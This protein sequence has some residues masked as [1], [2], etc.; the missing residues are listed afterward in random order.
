VNVTPVALHSTR[1][2]RDVLRGH[3][4][5]DGRAIAAAGGIHPLA[6]H[7]TGLSQDGLEALVQVGG[8][9]GLEVV[10]GD[11]W[12]LLAGSRSRLSAFAR[13]WTVPDVL[14]ETA[15]QVGLALP[16]DSAGPWLTSR[17]PISLDAPILIGILNVTPDSFSDGGRYSGLDAALS[18]AEALLAEGAGIVDVGGESTRPGRETD[19]PL[20]EELSRVVPV[21]D[22]LV[23]AHPELPISVDTVK[24]EVARAALEHGAAIVND[25]SAFRLDPAMPAVAASARA[26]VVLMHSR[27]NILEIASY[28]HARYPAGVVAEVVAELRESIAVA[29]AGGVAP[30]RIVIDPGLGFSKTVEQ[31]VELFDQLGALEALGRPVLVG[32]SRKRFLGALTDAPLDQRDRA[33]AV[34]CALAWER[35][36][37]IF[38]VHAVAAAR[39]A[40]ALARAVGAA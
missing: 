28:R 37:R 29:A 8:S 7:L 21:I 14:A 24:S 38:R 39:E 19:V 16:P 30:E 40:L 35:G 26:G 25:V 5:E 32:P 18:Q 1:G 23:R 2:L 34:A 3:G 33:T 31:N 6:L 12:A 4:W 27:G 15:V 9:L 11:D 17:G 20:A 36:A 13:P 10:T 22:A